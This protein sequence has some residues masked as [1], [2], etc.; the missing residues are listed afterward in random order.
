LQFVVFL[1]RINAA[2]RLYNIKDFKITSP[3]EAQKGRFHIVNF[4][5]TIDTFKFNASYKE[6]SGVAEIESEFDKKEPKERV[7]GKK[8]AKD[9]GGED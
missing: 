6:S 9:D 2:E 8:K 4:D 3:A 5:T 1:E 7:R